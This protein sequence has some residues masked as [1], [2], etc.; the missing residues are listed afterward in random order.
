[1]STQEKLKRLESNAVNS[2]N[3]LLN[4]VQSELSEDVTPFDILDE[5]DNK[6]QFES[7]LKKKLNRTIKHRYDNQ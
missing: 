5:V 4:F 3:D 6:L 2:L 7:S 1:M